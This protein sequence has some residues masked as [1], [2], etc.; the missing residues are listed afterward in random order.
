[1]SGLQPW[2]TIELPRFGDARGTLTVIEGLKHLPFAIARAYYI[3]DVPGI[4][5]RGQHA[6]RNL[7]RVLIALA[8]KFEV[9]VE[10]SD[11]QARFTLS[12]PARGLYVAPMVWTDI[13]GFGDDAVL[14][15]LVS[16]GYEE[17]DYIRDHD[18]YL[19]EVKVRAQ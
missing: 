7:H 12:D 18:H 16:H 13:A 3:Y 5:H 6:H 1:M 19:R 14:L 2:T 17:G 9:A 8:G 15:S 10:N 4:V 11:T